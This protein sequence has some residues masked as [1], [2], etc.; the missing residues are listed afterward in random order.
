M[1]NR[2]HVLSSFVAAPFAFPTLGHAAVP[3]QLPRSD[4]VTGARPLFHAAKPRET[5]FCQRRSRRRQD[6]NR[7]LRAD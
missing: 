6:D 2:R 4:A 5:G 7:R 1:P 3:E